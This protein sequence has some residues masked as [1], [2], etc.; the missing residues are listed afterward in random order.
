MGAP[1]RAARGM[2]ATSQRLASEVGVALL[3]RGGSAVDAAIGANAMLSLIEPYMCGPGGD[4]FAIVWDPR[5]E[6]LEGLNASGRAPH[7]QTLEALR[8]RLGGAASIPIAGPASVTVPGAVRGWQALHERWGRLS[9]DDIFAPVIEHAAAGVEIGPRTAVWWDECAR[10]VTGNRGL[11]SLADDFRAT[12]L[13]EGRA[14][15]RGE[16]FA[17]PCLGDFYASLAREGFAAYYEGDLAARLAAYLERKGSAITVSDL[18]AATAEWVAP[19][20]T[21]YR[22][23]EVHELPPNGQGLAVLQML[24][25]L[26]QFPLGEHG[27]A[28]ADYRHWFIEAK[29][30]AFEDR[31]RYYADPAF[32]DVPVAALNDKRYAAERATLVGA[33]ASAA[34][35]PGDPALS[36]GDTT[37]LSV[38]DAHGLMV[39]LIQSIFVGFGSGLVPDGSGYPLQSRGAAFALDPTHPNVYAPG[40]RPFHTIIPAFVTRDGAPLMSLGVMGADMQPQGQVQVLVNMIDFGLDPQAAG[41][42]ARIRHDGLNAPNRPQRSDAGV[43]WHEPEVDPACVTE[44]RRRGHD[45]RVC[46]EP[47]LHFMGGY[48]CVRREADGYSGASEPRFDGCALGL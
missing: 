28:S 9:L 44:L 43:V 29:K 24:N 46:T 33:R 36:R 21:T 47:V 41:D 48:E 35:V 27:P 5:A 45:V 22:D 12:F 40:K 10:D 19:I 23:V 31:A 42:A 34:P 20:S 26:E 3:G 7:G 39:S 38:A 2:V 11:G 37:Y 17:N 25:V 13:L 4:L 30:L 14:P 16:R 18:A 8:A 32:A 1:V 15:R 6:R